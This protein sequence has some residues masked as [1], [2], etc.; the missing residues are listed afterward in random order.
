MPDR[1]ASIVRWA[2]GEEGVDLEGVKF[3][4]ADAK[5]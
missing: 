1:L 4:S 2:A 5:A 3:D